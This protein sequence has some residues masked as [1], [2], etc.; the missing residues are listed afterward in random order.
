[1]TT[2]THP[3]VADE[4][5]IRAINAEPTAV[6]PL[7]PTPDSDDG[8]VRAGPSEGDGAGPAAAPLSDVDPDLAAMLTPDMVAGGVVSPLFDFIATRRGEHWRVNDA[9]A[10]SI[11]EPLT[12]ELQEFA[13]RA[14]FLVG[15]A[16]AVGG[17]RARLLI[18]TATVVGPRLYVDRALAA[19]RA[20]AATSARAQGTPQGEP[21]PKT[22]P[23]ADVPAEPFNPD[24]ASAD[25]GDR[26]AGLPVK[27]L[28]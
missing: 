18:A 24:G 2:A 1:M 3:P 27:D 9:E 20:E 14:P 5:E 7:G 12:V 19:E 4:A 28:S 26:L 22:E 17:N 13:T 25:F 6:G 16:H 23:R 10:M 11:A 15:A 8:P 21:R